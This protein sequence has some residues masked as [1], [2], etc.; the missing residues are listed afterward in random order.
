[1]EDQHI[2]G[3]G[4]AGML[5][6]I[7]FADVTSV[8]RTC[9]SCGERAA[10]AAHPAYHGA[11]VVLRCPNC[12]DVAVAVGV[13]DERLVMEWNGAFEWPREVRATS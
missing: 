13:S 4:F 3:N 12:S 10:L 8:M 2:D 6:E 5:S 1:M 9:Q 7:G 11:G